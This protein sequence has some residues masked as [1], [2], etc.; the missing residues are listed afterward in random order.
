M[1]PLIIVL[2]V[3]VMVVLV[4][5]VGVLLVVWRGRHGASAHKVAG[6]GS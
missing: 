1:E 6:I 2:V 3:A 5:V 4:L